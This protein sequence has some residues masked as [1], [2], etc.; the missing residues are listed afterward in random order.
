M[1]GPNFATPHRIYFMGDDRP[2]RLAGISN[3]RGMSV[4]VSICLLS[5]A[6]A[7]HSAATEAVTSIMEDQYADPESTS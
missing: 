5:R 7:H 4:P 2:L 3:K 6:V 1:A